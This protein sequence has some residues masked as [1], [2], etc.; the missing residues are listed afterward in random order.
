MEMKSNQYKLIIKL[1]IMWRI[2]S[3]LLHFAS[4]KLYKYG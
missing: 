3:C 2:N 1:I 4:Q